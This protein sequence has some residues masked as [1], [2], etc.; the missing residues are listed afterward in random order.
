MVPLREQSFPLYA[1]E[2]GHEVHV[3][4]DKYIENSIKDSERQ[5][6]GAVDAIYTITGPEQTMRQRGQT[7]L[8]NGTFKNELGKFLMKEWGEKTTTG[9]ST[10]GRRYLLH[11]VANAF[12]SGQMQHASKSQSQGLL[13]Y[14]PTTKR[15]IPLSASMWLTSQ[16]RQS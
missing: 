6:R 13:T 9:T 8:R 3:C 1:V 2:E 11:M 7:L 4:L 16:K 10:V 5:L 14:R 15:Q 12:S